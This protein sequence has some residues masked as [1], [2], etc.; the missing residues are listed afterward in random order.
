MMLFR[1]WQ[2]RLMPNSESHFPLPLM[3]MLGYGAM[4][5]VLQ[6]HLSL[7]NEAGV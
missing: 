6:L 5:P 3:F 4:I 2:P 1:L 7:I